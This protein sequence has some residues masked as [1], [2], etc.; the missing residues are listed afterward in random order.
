M[1]YSDIAVP[2]GTVITA[3]KLVFDLRT[4]STKCSHPASGSS[5]HSTGF[6]LE[7]EWGLWDLEVRGF[8]MPYSISR[9]IDNVKSPHFPHELKMLTVSLGGNRRMGLV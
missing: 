6:Q 2:L 3:T 8:R 5:G 4:Q 7:G 1:E 9:D